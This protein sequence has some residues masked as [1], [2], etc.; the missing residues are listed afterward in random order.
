MTFASCTFGNNPFRWNQ[1]NETITDDQKYTQ[2]DLKWIFAHNFWADGPIWDSKISMNSSWRGKSSDHFKS[3]GK[4]LASLL[5]LF[6]YWQYIDNMP[7]CHKIIVT[8]LLVARKL[9]EVIQK[10]A[11]TVKAKRKKCFVPSRSNLFVKC[12]LDKCKF[13]KKKS[14]IM[15][16]PAG[17][18]VLS[19]Q[20]QTWC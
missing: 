11:G 5:F 20:G 12:N 15:W 17:R 14:N 2:F 16:R 13:V 4:R 9:Q 7:C 3:V 10:A 6:R 19:H 8:L 1:N 18:S